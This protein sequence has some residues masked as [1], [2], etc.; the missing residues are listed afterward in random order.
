MAVP[1]WNR[2]FFTCP[3]HTRG[4]LTWLSRTGTTCCYV[5]RPPKGVSYMVVPSWSHVFSGVQ[6]TQGVC[7]MV[8]PSW[9]HV[10]P[11]KG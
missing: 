7:N 11:G 4:Y 8:V 10:F 6:A 1:S 5:S 3:G 2:V 9:N